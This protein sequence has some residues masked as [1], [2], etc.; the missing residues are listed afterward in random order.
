MLLRD[1]PSSR[2]D[3]KLPP[4]PKSL[5]RIASLLEEFAAP[6][7]AFSL[8]PGKAVGVGGSKLGGAPD[9]PVAFRLPPDRAPIDF[10]LQINLAEASPLDQTAAL[11]PSG[12]L[13]FFYDLNEQPW[14][15][16]PKRLNGFCVHHTPAGVPLV[17]TPMPRP[18]HVLGECRIDLRAGL[19]LPHIGSRVYGHFDQ[20]ANLNDSEAEAYFAYSEE[21]ERL[22]GPKRGNHHLLGHSDNVQGDMQ[23]EAQLVTNGLYCGN[24]TG[25]KDPRRKALE[26]G[27]DDWMLLL[28]L[29]SDDT[30]EFMWG[31]LGMLYYW[32][33]KQDLA[34]NRF[35]SV[36]MTLQC[37]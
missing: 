11:L 21:V 2:P 18:D 22:G 7:I 25:Y 23:L 31:D 26:A 37:G 16:D 4:V 17:R 27:A 32:I 6:S 15:F 14:G 3:M 20:L 24:E 30:A 1:G 36:W 8:E 33:R 5:G 29:D 12:L 34:E 9:L 35:D 13:S 19:T 10:L 28:Q